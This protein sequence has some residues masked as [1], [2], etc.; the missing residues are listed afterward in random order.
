[1]CFSNTPSLFA[2]DPL[3]YF[4]KIYSGL[5]TLTKYIFFS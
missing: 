3:A 5:Q 1:M 2:T 4:N